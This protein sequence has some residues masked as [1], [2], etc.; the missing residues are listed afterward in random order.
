MTAAAVPAFLPR[1][2]GSV[3]WS[4]AVF[5]AALIGYLV[6]AGE[7]VGGPS[8]APYFVALARSFL[9]GRA[10]LNM[11]GLSTYDLIP[12]NGGWY[13][14]QPPLPA[15][16]L[17]PYVALSAAPSDV[18]FGVVIGAVSVAVCERVLAAAVPDLPRF[19]RLA[20]T[21][22]FGFGSAHL[23]LSTMGTVWFLGQTSAV[24]FVW[25]FLAAVIARQP[26]WAGIALGAVL[27]ARPTIGFGAVACALLYW[28]WGTGWLRRGVLLAA[29]LA[30]ACVFL[31]VYNY[32]RFDSFTDFGYG[33]LNDADS[34]RERR[35]TYG[36]FSPAF[37][38]EN[39]YVATIK[40]PAQIDLACVIRPDCAAVTPDLWGLGLLWTNPLL[41]AALAARRSRLILPAALATGL[42][43]LPSLLYHNTGSAQ[44]GYRFVMD[45]FPFWLLLVAI[46]VRR[47]PRWIVGGAVVYSVIVTV[48]GTLWLMRLL[49]P[50]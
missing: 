45:A 9:E 8:I 25:L 35:L 30:A 2:R 14:A 27:L 22:F 26:L 18:L 5:V 33:Y 43:V 36:G 17:L 39:L 38:P 21:A 41:L 4:L 49:I 20:L 48:A 7:H 42:I 32:V 3:L 40:P 23:Y 44:F 16:L 15:L 29:P 13:V 11:D 46:G 6:I 50:A 19:H 34:I 1:E 31:G 47:W 37:L 10:A 12:F 24:L 28:G